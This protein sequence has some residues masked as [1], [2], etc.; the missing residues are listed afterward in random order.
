MMSLNSKMLSSLALRNL[1]FSH[2]PVYSSMSLLATAASSQRH[3]SYATKK[4]GPND[5]IKDER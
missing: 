3:F 5:F 4:K 1:Y 2:Q